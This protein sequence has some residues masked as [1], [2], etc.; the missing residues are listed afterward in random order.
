MPATITK[1]QN[2]LRS[3]LER[4]GW[5]WYTRPQTYQCD[6]RVRLTNPSNALASG[7][8]LII[9]YPATTSTQQL[10]KVPEFEPAPLVVERVA[11][12]HPDRFVC[13]RLNIQPK[14]TLEYHERF[15][16][17]VW[18]VL[19]SAISLRPPQRTR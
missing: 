19:G 6:Y 13:W 14:E 2:F 15:Q 8:Y 12:D 16:V 10:L 4:R 3:P 1:I 9:P 11:P 7:R 18:P 5:T 17:R